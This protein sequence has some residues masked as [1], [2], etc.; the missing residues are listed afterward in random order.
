MFLDREGAY[1]KT[2]ANDGFLFFS[3]NIYIEV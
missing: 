1:H 3:K 2:E